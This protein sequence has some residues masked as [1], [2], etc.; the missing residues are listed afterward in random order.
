MTF[1]ISY[2]I[3]SH[4]RTL[5]KHFGNFIFD[6][7][8]I[9]C[10]EFFFIA[11]IT[12]IYFYIKIH[13]ISISFT[14]KITFFCV[15]FIY[16]QDIIHIIIPFDNYILLAFLLLIII[17]LIL[18][19]NGFFYKF[20]T[21]TNNNISEITTSSKLKEDEKNKI[22]IKYYLNENNVLNKRIYQ[23]LK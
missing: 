5:K 22:L 6:E 13:F 1:F 20:K 3:Y 18:N 14:L 9:V 11:Y 12:F 21:I 10:K 16:E 23:V 15:K 19:Y 17:I 8:T 2:V 7:A 4:F